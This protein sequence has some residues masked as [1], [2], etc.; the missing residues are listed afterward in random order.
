MVPMPGYGFFWITFSGEITV[1]R[2]GAA[3]AEFRRHP[4]FEPGVDEL[5]DFSGTSIN[6]LSQ[7]DIVLIR[8]F[9][10]ER[11]DRHHI[12]S[13][14]VVGSAVDYG[15]GRM[16]G[17]LVEVDEEVPVSYHACRSVREALEWLRPGQEDE[18]L[19]AYAEAS[20]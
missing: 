9:M 2:L 19:A 7:Q 10:K 5:L 13:A 11:T 16:F 4:A 17:T 15:V 8:R 3:H 18:L 14:I 20:G 6:L 1:E 12:K